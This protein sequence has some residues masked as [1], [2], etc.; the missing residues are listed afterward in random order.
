MKKRMHA[1][2]SYLNDLNPKG[3]V[4]VFAGNEKGYA[5]IVNLKRGLNIYVHHTLEDQLTI[6]L[7]ITEAAENDKIAVEKAISK[8]NQFQFND[9]KIRERVWQHSS[10]KNDKRRQYYFDVTD[11][12]DEDIRKIFDKIREEFANASSQQKA[13]NHNTPAPITYLPTKA[14]IDFADSQL[15]KSPDEVID[16]NDVLYKVEDNFINA[17][18]PL[19]E[20]WR[21][22][23]KR[24]I[25]LWFDKK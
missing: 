4:K 6:D 18:K 12:S 13:M 23:T 16:A 2:A 24:N 8:F 20:N 14:D 11:L 7:L 1:H 10:N 15:R 25:E 17:G 22:I 19:R 21:Y 9:K 3:M 5:S